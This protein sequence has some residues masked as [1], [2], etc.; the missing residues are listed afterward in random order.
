[1]SPRRPQVLPDVLAPDLRVVFCGTA[2][3]T[4]SARDG[5][6]YAHPGNYFW[7]TLFETGLTP[8]RLSPHE[9]PRVPEFGIGLTDLA[10][11]HF[12]ADHE[13]PRDAFDA[14]SL[15]RKI[16]RC[17]P[18]IIAF[19]SKNAAY[20]Y[21]GRVLAYGEQDER[22]ATS[23]VFVLPSPSGQARKF[24]DIE[25]WHELARAVRPTSRRGAHA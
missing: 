19:T 2:A 3:G 23:R 16:A 21:F 25:P 20:G 14:A 5:A 7:R 8:R 9:F 17:K 13:L 12:G 10:K 18:R 24:W 11:R 1:M 4:R 15:Q 22:V 6:Y